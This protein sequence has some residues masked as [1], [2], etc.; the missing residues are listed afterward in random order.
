MRRITGGGTTATTATSCNLFKPSLTRPIPTVQTHQPRGA[1]LILRYH[2]V[3][4]PHVVI[5]PCPKEGCCLR[6]LRL[7]RVGRSLPCSL[8]GCGVGLLVCC[9]LKN[10][11]DFAVSVG[12]MQIF[13]RSVGGETLALEVDSASTVRDV[14]EQLQL[15]QGRVLEREDFAWSEYPR[16]CPL[17]C[18]GRL[19]NYS[20]S[21]ECTSC[22]VHSQFSPHRHTAASRLLAQPG[23]PVSFSGSFLQ[24][25]SWV[26]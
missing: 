26:N 22:R 13:V 11:S 10:G 25:D 4:A 21:R 8:W 16:L 9:A 1:R 20:G 2:L 18:F 15:R 14:K 5:L 17:F 23:C 3:T 19:G 6:F 12:M 7:E 24:L